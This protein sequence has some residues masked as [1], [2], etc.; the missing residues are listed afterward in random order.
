MINDSMHI[1]VY[2]YKYIGISIYT[3]KPIQYINIAICKRLVNMCIDNIYIYVQSI[4]GV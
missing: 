2:L 3:V 1:L 4:F